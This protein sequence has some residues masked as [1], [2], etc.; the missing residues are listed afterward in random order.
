MKGEV[1]P[2]LADFIS[3][4]NIDNESAISTG[5][6]KAAALDTASAGSISSLHCCVLLSAFQ[7]TSV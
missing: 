4:L 6:F 2:V 3:A 1:D 5:S 7:T